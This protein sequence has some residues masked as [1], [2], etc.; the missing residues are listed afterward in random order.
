[1]VRLQHNHRENAKERK[2]ERMNEGGTRKQKVSSFS[3]FLFLRFR[4]FAF[5]LLKAEL[6]FFPPFPVFFAAFRAFA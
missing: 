3:L 2:G 6:F 5:L 4:S 1:M